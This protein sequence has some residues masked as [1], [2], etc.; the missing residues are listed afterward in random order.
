M[1]LKVACSPACSAEDR[2]W[3]CAASDEEPEALGALVVVEAAAAALVVVVVLVEPVHAADRTAV[4][5]RP[6]AH[7]RHEARHALP[8]AEAEGGGAS[9]TVG[10][11]LPTGQC[12]APG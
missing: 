12:P 7:A 8:E 2:D 4:H 11:G 6:M 5:T 10:L 1:A 3:I 9:G